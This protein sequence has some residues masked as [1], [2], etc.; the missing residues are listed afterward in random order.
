MVYIV[1]LVWFNRNKKGEVF[2]KGANV[3]VFWT[4]KEAKDT[5]NE[6]YTSF[7]SKGDKGYKF[8]KE[9]RIVSDRIIGESCWY[10]RVDIVSTDN[11][12]DKPIE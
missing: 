8:M 11:D 1:T 6:L 5:L 12:W 10:G 2:N 7:Y 9:F 3:R 4:E